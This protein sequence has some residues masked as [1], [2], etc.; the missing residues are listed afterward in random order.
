EERNI[1][2]QLISDAVHNFDDEEMGRWFDVFVD[3]QEYA[4]ALVDTLKEPD[5]NPELSEIFERRFKTYAHQ[6][7]NNLAAAAG[8]GEMNRIPARD[9]SFSDDSLSEDEQDEC[10]NVPTRRRRHYKRKRGDLPKLMSMIRRRITPPNDDGG[11]ADDEMTES[12][13]SGSECEDEVE[14]DDAPESKRLRLNVPQPRFPSGS[15]NVPSKAIVV[16]M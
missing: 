6:L 13:W 8:Q 14:T 12:E 11:E 3:D 10:G 1:E 2:L 4:D 16:L 5:V 7:I 15:V 9:E